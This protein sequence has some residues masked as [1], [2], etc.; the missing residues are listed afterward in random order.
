MGD[1]DLSVEA[2]RDL[3]WTRGLKEKA[4]GLAQVGTRFLNAVALAGDVQLRTER[5]EPIALSFDDCG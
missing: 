5:D 1:V 2:L 4:E 3:L